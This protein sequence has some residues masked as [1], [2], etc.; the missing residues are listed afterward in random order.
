MTSFLNWK[1]CHHKHVFTSL[2]NPRNFKRDS[3]LFH[4]LHRRRIWIHSEQT[5]FLN[6]GI[7]FFSYFIAFLWVRFCTERT[8]IYR[9]VCERETKK[10]EHMKYIYGSKTP[11]LWY[12]L[13][14]L[15][16]FSPSHSDVVNIPL[17]RNMLFSFL[18]SAWLFVR[19]ILRKGAKKKMWINIFSFVS[20]SEPQLF[21]DSLSHTLPH[22]LSAYFPRNVM[23]YT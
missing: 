14:F 12:S 10:R 18:R 1:L 5:S 16:S 6:W 20:F 11:R 2:R 21:L 22:T 19:Y 23:A 8:C 4:L 9:S 17:T 7:Q 13:H 3:Y 15:S